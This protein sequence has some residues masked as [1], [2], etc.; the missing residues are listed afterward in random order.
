[1]SEIQLVILSSV[2]ILTILTTLI[3]IQVSLVFRD[4]KRV[5]ERMDRL[6]A[7]LQTLS[8]L[9]TQ[10]TERQVNPEIATNLPTR[11]E[12]S[13]TKARRPHERRSERTR[14]FFRRK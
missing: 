12:D 14:R 2:V 1:M 13:A 7:N 3:A 10:S 5:I 9:L 8:S 11:E 4:F 6:L